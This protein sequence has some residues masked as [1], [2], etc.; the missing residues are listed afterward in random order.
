MRRA[1]FPLVLLVIALVYPV[2]TAQ[3]PVYQRLGALVAGLLIGVVE[4]LSAYLI[5][6]I[7]KEVIVYA[8]FVLVLW[9][10]PQGL[11]GKA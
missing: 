4:S 6:P 8:L 3:Y 5:G 1:W 2:L 10:R 9:F 11:M 7:Y